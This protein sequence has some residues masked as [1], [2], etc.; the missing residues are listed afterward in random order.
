MTPLEIVKKRT[1]R[2][3]Y[4]SQCPK[5]EIINNTHFCGESGKILLPQFVYP[6]EG[7]GATYNCSMM[8]WKGVKE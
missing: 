5:L 2:V 6:H 4:C 8:A 1:E 7:N 3:E